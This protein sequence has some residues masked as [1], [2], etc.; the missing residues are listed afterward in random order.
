MCAWD[1]Y[2]LIR[3]LFKTLI[4]GP[5]TAHRTWY[6]ILLSQVPSE[7]R[8]VINTVVP[9]KQNQVIHAMVAR[10]GA[11]NPHASRRRQKGWVGFGE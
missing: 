8:N 7:A 4:V 1:T 2:E 11:R 6:S 3:Q 9:A 10:T 5:D